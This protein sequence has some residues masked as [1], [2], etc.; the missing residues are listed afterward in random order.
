MHSQSINLAPS[1]TTLAIHTM[2][3]SRT[4]TFTKYP[5]KFERENYKE[6]LEKAFQLTFFY[7]A[8][9]YIMVIVTTELSIKYIRR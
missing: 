3:S 4:C 1:R 2:V 7:S 5:P 9:V 8:Y 6:N